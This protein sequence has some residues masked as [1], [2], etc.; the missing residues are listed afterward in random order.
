M[1]VKQMNKIKK[2][3]IKKQQ[4]ENV[5]ISLYAQNEFSEQ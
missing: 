1:C 5:K 2:T 4:Q 3:K